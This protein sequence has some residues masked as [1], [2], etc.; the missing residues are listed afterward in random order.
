MKERSVPTDFA[1]ADLTDG[2]GRLEWG[3]KYTDS[4]AR[5]SIRFEAIYLAVLL[6]SVPISILVLWLG[7][8]RRWLA[9]SEETYRPIMRYGL[10]WLSGMLGGTLLGV[11]WLYHVVAHQLWHLDRRLWRL[12]TPHISGALAFVVIALISSK[13]LGLLDRETIQSRPF[14]VGVAFIVGYFSDNALARLAGIAEN[15]FGAKQRKEKRDDRA[16]AQTNDTRRPEDSRQVT[17]STTN[18]SDAIAT[19]KPEVTNEDKNR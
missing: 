11:K 8:P 14:I 18:T 3:S 16:R 7:Y 19:R 12:F 2:R 10:A 5:R 9:L 13:A 4:A 15:F 17:E 6:F 1:P